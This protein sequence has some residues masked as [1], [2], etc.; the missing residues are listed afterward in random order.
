MTEI[1]DYEA[2][3]TAYD[4]PESTLSWRLRTVQDFIRAAFDS[5]PGPVRVV[6]SCAGDGRD[7]LGVLAEREDASRFATTL[8]ELHPELAARARSAAESLGPEAS[9]EVRTVDAG[10][11]DAYA[12][13]VPADLVLMVGV[14]GNI[15]DEDLARTVAAMPQLCA[16]GATLVWTHGRWHEDRNDRVRQ[17][18]GAAG[19]VET[20]YATLDRGSRPAVGV[21]RY[22]GPG[23]PLGLGRPLFTFV[24]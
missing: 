19:F 10:S 5:R 20:D 4:D 23:E 21:E 13:A 8:L 14:F 7:V 17:W 16:P 1:R 2:W 11:T 22:E 24:Q 15:S 6:S 3:H 9:V 12:G 18:F